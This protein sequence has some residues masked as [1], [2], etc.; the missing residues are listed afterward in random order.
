M[1]N[2][3]ETTIYTFNY[4]SPYCAPLDGDPSNSISGAVMKAK[5]DSM[6]FALT[7]LSLVPPPEYRPYYAGWNNTGSL[8][9]GVIL[10]KLHLISTS[11]FLMIINRSMLKTDS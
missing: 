1:W 6:D 5:Y 11:R 10:K 3:A 9:D 4:E 2:Y 8:S 7:E